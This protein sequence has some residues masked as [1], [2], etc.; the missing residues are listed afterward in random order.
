MKASRTKIDRFTV[1]VDGAQGGTALAAG[2]SVART[3]SLAM[4][5][6]SAASVGVTLTGTSGNDTFSPTATA[7]AFRTTANA[8]TISGL[9]GNDSLNGGAGADTMIGG[10]GNDIYIVDNL[11]DKT[12]EAA[13][14]GTDTVNASLSWTLANNIEN[15]TLTGTAAINATGN[16]LAN[17]LT[18]NSA[19]NTLKG[20]GGNDTLNGGSGDDWIDG[21][22]GND[23]I[24]GGDGNDVIY[25]TAGAPAIDAGA[26]NDSIYI[27]SGATGTVNGGTGRDIL[28]FLSY[29]FNDVPGDVDLT[30]LTMIGVEVLQTGGNNV[31]ATVAQ[32]EAFDAILAYPASWDYLY[33]VS[34]ITLTISGA[35]TLDI[36]D[37]MLL[38]MSTSTNASATVYASSNGNTVTTSSGD[39]TLYGGTGNDTLNGESGND[40]L[41]GNAG[42]DT[43]DG[44][45]GVDT[46]SYADKTVSVSVTLNRATAVRVTVGGVNEDM[47][48]NIENI[49]GGSSDD[50]LTGDSLGN[51]LTGGAGNDTL[52]GGAGNDTIID[53]AG[54]LAI[55]GGAGDDRITIAEG[56][57]G[58]V[59]GGTGR[60]VLDFSYDDDFYISLAASLVITGGEI[61]ETQGDNMITAT[62]AQFEAFDK[63]VAGDY[64]DP[65]QI[66]LTISGAGTLDLSDE[67]SDFDI[68][69]G[70]L[71]TRR[72]AVVHASSAGNTITTGGLGDYLYGGTGNDTLNGGAGGDRLD[73]NAGDDVLNGGAG[74]DW[75]YDLAGTLAIDGGAGD[76]IIHI[77]D[78]QQGTVN[79]GTGRDVLTT[80]GSFAAGLT[81][82]GVE[83][84]ATLY[85]NVAATAAQFEAFDKIA[86]SDDAYYDAYYGVTLTISG[87]GTLDLTGELSE[88]VSGSLVARRA[89]T[90]YASSAGNTITTGGLADTLYGL[91]GNDR[92]NGNA[93]N[94]MLDGGAGNDTLNGSVGNDTLNGGDGN[95]TLYGSVGNDSLNGGAGA[96]KLYGGLGI[97][98]LL[99]GTGADSFVFNTALSASTNLDRISDFSVVDDTIWLDDAVFTAVSAAS[100]SSAD[101]RIGTAT[102]NSS[103]NIIYNSASGGLFYDADGVGSAA[104]IQFATLSAGLALTHND[105]LII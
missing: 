15:L 42:N 54:T 75:I 31:T 95:D 76:D 44:G 96:D 57:T 35:G 77:A 14:E 71:V 69:S 87:A 94:D 101:F 40:L 60:D 85:N 62:V 23:T 7:V 43:L 67:V 46:A 26:G 5:G 6:V 93:G 78:G 27:E 10:L 52:N 2:A 20:L 48:R 56:L 9:A 34:R 74:D 22:D 84:L 91:A 19:A 104:A 102:V 50:T 98:V 24:V 25:D 66:T 21:G 92:L 83:V 32:F 36:A 89:A 63:I 80:Y 11:G 29:D 47:I 103:Q 16:A 72:A 99:G 51:V 55:D 105:F 81:T 86:Y 38:L 59:N 33:D 65:F 28:N 12:V 64:A 4:T 73:G 3:A 82:T 45:A 13:G 37:E 68:V 41:S 39:D 61:L 30:N 58:T 1:P 97:D 88:M 100:W 18:G 79:C 53:T 49:I 8:D 17:I 70:S 90:V